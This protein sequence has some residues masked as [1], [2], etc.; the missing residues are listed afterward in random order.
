MTTEI[1]P[2]DVHAVVDGP[3]GAPVVVLAGSLGSTLEMWRPQVGP[4]LAAGLRVVRYDHRGHG[5]SPVP[6]GPYSIAGLGGD[7]L[8]LLDRIGAERASVAGVSLG[9]M[10]G[11]WAAALH[12]ERINRLALLCTSALLGPPEGWTD[13]A[14]TVRAEG[15][16][17]V[18]GPVVGRWFTPA[19]A[20]REPEAVARMRDTVAAT[21]PEG[22]AGC[23][24]AIADMDL[25]P[26]LPGIGAPTLV[27][28]GGDDPATPAEHA[29]AIAGLI[30]GARLHVLDGGA[31]LA[32][33]ECADQVNPLLVE[34]LT[35][36]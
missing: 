34:H 26:E 10:V 9:G 27:L 31:H 30:P 35:R 2:V 12:P 29:R 4:L 17:A 21:P 5:G 8:R 36:R 7:L 13:R 24:E 15:T 23:C 33:W 1:D 6:P 28:A 22:Y 14:A 11:M 18:A 16:G 20:E 25:R 3:A 19:Y 32:S